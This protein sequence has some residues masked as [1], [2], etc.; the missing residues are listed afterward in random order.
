[1]YLPSNQ[2]SLAATFVRLTRRVLSRG[3]HG[4]CSCPSA[5]WLAN[6]QSGLRRAIRRH[7]AKSL[8]DGFDQIY[9]TV[10]RLYDMPPGHQDEHPEQHSTQCLM[11]SRQ[12][13]SSTV[14]SG[15]LLVGG[16]K[17]MRGFL[18]THIMLVTQPTCFH[19]TGLRGSMVL[20]TWGWRPT[21]YPSSGCK[22]R[23]L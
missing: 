14:V 2:L 23:I 11:S 10:V 16:V 13:L 22:D 18:K 17:L 3:Q 20:C 8:V 5:E 12:L 15:M 21:F 19:T 1:M 4:A 9:F 6:Y 7:P